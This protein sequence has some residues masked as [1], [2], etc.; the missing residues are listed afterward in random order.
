MAAPA[1]PTFSASELPAVLSGGMAPPRSAPP[2]PGAPVASLPDPEPL[3][4]PVYDNHAHL[5]ILD[6]DQPLSLTE[7][8]DRAQAVGIA[9]AQ[10]LEDVK[11][12]V[13][14]SMVRFAEI[15][16]KDDAE[17]VEQIKGIFEAIEEART[18][19]AA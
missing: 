18:V 14:G 8:L 7:Q 4:V 10:V 17:V 13:P 5:E 19:A 16:P 11:L 9:G 1:V 3:A 12:A 2:S 15:H 6:G